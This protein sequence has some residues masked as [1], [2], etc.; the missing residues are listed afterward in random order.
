MQS[1]DLP[2]SASDVIAS[3]HHQ[4]IRIWAEDG[5]LF[6]KAPKKGVDR[7]ML[8]QLAAKKR[9]ILQILTGC[10]KLTVSNS[11][12]RSRESGSAV[13]LAYSQLAHWNLYNLHHMPSRCHVTSA[14]AIEGNLKI[15]V[16][17][18][19]ISAVVSRHD[20]LRTRIVL[21]NGQ[22]LQEIAEA[23]TFDFRLDDLRHI[24][25]GSRRSTANE[26]IEKY[27][28]E[29]INIC[30]VPL[31]RVRLFRIAEADH[32]LLLSMEHI[33][34]DGFSMGILLRSVFS[35]YRDLISNQDISL[36]EVQTQFTEYA[37]T[38][39]LAH[40]ARC[41]SQQ[42]YWNEHFAG[43]QRVRFPETGARLQGNARRWRILQ[44]DFDPSLRARLEHWARS[45]S[46]TTV[47]AAFTAYAVAVLRWCKVRDAVF[48]F[49]VDGRDDVRMRETIGYLAFPLYLKVQIDAMDNF[50]TVLSKVTEEYCLAYEHS[51]FSIAEA[52]VP[53]PEFTRNSCFNWMPRDWVETLACGEGEDGIKIHLLPYDLAI[54]DDFDR[55]AE[56]MLGITDDGIDLRGCLQFSL[57]RHSEEAMTEFLRVYLRILT[58]MLEW[59]E[60]RIVEHF[61]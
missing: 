48:L 45:R 51:G 52:Q 19:A 15:P 2:A 26:L 43:S 55:D 39:S 8:E 21:R 23:C 17:L 32:I 46:T 20:S 7:H 3:A 61:V 36:P 14:T 56:P 18:S 38:E 33:I 34:A 59:P 11:V 49:Q 42:S 44:F 5:R 30:N 27:Q 50:L 29:P 60:C 6:Y 40:E 57:G 41:R 25:E 54:V 58:T 35:A 9:D 47:L 22:P 31:F 10:E 16:L 1:S 12:A 24:Q 4:G 28:V 53:R 37:Q 13:P